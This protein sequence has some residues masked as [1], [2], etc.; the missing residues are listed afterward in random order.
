M[1]IEPVLWETHAHPELGDR[2][3][4]I[5]NRQIV[6]AC[7]FVVG[8]FWMRLGMA[9]GV[10]VSGT[11]EEI[12]RFRSNSK[13]VLLYFSTA[14]IAPNRI[15]QKQYEALRDYQRSVNATGLTF[16]YATVTEFQRLFSRQL[17]SVM[18]SFAASQAPGASPE[19]LAQALAGA[20][21][22]AEKEQ[23]VVE[24]LQAL[25]KHT[26][27]FWAELVELSPYHDSFTAEMQSH[28]FERVKP[29]LDYLVT[30]GHLSYRT[31]HAYDTLTDK[32]PVLNIIVENVTTQLK[33]LAKH[34]GKGPQ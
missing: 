25:K 7:D 28:T 30:R 22:G 33:N 4:A 32:I 19:T 16:G 21:S 26:R 23:D 13:P 17:A 2:P 6:D 3:Q 29:W 24:I 15:D 10:A 14:K 27:Y 11:A 1:V 34:V 18:S 5:L 12:E 8:V 31:E 20:A 9:T